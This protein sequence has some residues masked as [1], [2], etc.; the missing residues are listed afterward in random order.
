IVRRKLLPAPVTGD[1]VSLV[2]ILRKN[3]GK[4]LSTISMPI[5]LNEPLN[6]LQ[7]LCEELEY[8]ELL[9]QAASCDDS[10]MRLAYIAAFAVS[11]Y[12]STVSRASRKPFN[13]L[14]GETYE[15]ERVDKGFRYISEKVSHNPPIMAC[16]AESLKGNYSFWQESKVKSKFWGK[17][18]EFIP[19][20]NVHVTL[21]KWGEQYTWSK[22]TTCMRN[23]ISGPKSLDHY[24]SMTITN[25]STG[26]YAVLTFKENSSGY[27]S[28]NN[29]TKNE[30]AGVLYNSKK[31]KTK[32]L[33]GR[34]SDT[35]WICDIDDRE[36]LVEIWR[37]N[38]DNQH[39][40]EDMY[41]LTRFAI[42]LN[43]I[44]P[45]LPLYLP[46]TDTRYRPDQRLFEEGKLSEAE[47][48]KIRLEEKQRTV[49]RALQD[50]GKS[51]TPLWFRKQM[52][53][54]TK[55]EEWCFAGDYWKKREA[56]KGKSKDN[57]MNEVGCLDLFG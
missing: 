3:V 27:F 13:P 22:V 6:L 25:H 12:S 14:H 11:G 48:E 33:T 56:F 47:T 45:D 18:M 7:R 44:T 32:L 15:C 9:D 17:S 8:S 41:G 23:L 49:R 57:W 30:V 35:V 36:N 4:D 20:G 31:E 5:S 53:E 46:P 29:G 19:S 24:G 10:V 55:T 43:E 38:E 51:I 42:E 52:D 50:E 54:I 26:E 39:I 21:N 28:S 40:G 16:H 37:V 1:S 2:S 34:W